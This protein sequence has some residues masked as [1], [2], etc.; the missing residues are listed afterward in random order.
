MDCEDSVAGVDAEDKTLCYRNWLGLLTG[1][2]T[3][4]ITK[5]DRTFTRRANPDREFADLN[6]NP[7]KLNG[8][9]MMFIRNVGHLMTDAAIL[10]KDGNEKYE[11]MMDAVITSLCSSHDVKAKRTTKSVQIY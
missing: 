10:D 1:E 7:Q 4:E 5:G 2:L 11:G 3:E 9:S 8:R 6:G